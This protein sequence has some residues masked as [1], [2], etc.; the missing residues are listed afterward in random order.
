MDSK[1]S[2]SREM[3][4]LNELL[5]VI[6]IIV[7]S[8]AVAF[9]AGYVILKIT[10][11]YKNHFNVSMGPSLISVCLSL[12]LFVVAALLSSGNGNAE[13]ILI[14]NIIAFLLLV[15]GM[16]RNIRSYKKAAVGAI[17]FQLIMVCLQ[18]F[19]LIAAIMTIFIRKIFKHRN[20][21]LNTVL[22]WTKFIWNM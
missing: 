10:S 13:Y 2:N 5:I 7:V 17:V 12:D 16:Y 21:Q 22:N 19:I 4:R 14:F 11:Y 20:N 6:G 1:N 9:I 15:Y 8:I 18:M 3:I